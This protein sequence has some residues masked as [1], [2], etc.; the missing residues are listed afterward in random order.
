[1]G[2]K[3]RMIKAVRSVSTAVQTISTFQSSITFSFLRGVCLGMYGW[4]QTQESYN[5]VEE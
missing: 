2:I 1:M 5:K 4:T 3:L